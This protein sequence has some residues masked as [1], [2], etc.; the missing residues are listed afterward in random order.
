MMVETP[1]VVVKEALLGEIV[2]KKLETIERL[3]MFGVMIVFEKKK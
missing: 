2:P 1:M 3:T